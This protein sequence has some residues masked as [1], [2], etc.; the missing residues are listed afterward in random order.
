MNA[1]DRGAHVNAGI[2]KA[3]GARGNA[4]CRTLQIFLAQQPVTPARSDEDRAFAGRART[5]TVRC[6]P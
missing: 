5:G 1:A 3:F 6:G 2:H 4:G